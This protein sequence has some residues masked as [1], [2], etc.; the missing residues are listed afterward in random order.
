[1]TIWP[2]VHQLQAT[3]KAQ[4]AELAALK[5][6][7]EAL[8]ATQERLKSQTVR[9]GAGNDE[10]TRQLE[11]MG[12]GRQLGNGSDRP[13]DLSGRKLTGGS[14]ALKWSHGFLHSFADPTSAGCDLHA[15]LDDSSTGPL[16]MK[17]TP[18]GDVQMA[19]GSDNK[20]SISAPLTVEHP[21]G[22]AAASLVAGLPLAIPGMGM[23]GV[24]VTDMF[25]P[26]VK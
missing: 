8:R 14:T 7:R 2:A 4:A 18:S 3:V 17:R 22:C 25:F 24:D 6:N 21:S 5:A 16:T 1:M 9:L 11:T 20:F 23:E 12:A 26:S 15:D 13:T 19:Y 10:L